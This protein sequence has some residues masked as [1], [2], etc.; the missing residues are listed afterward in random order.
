MFGSLVA[1]MSTQHSEAQ[2]S[3]AG[4]THTLYC[5]VKVPSWALRSP[6]T[7]PQLSTGA[8]QPCPSFFELSWECFFEGM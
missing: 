4:L 2:Q 6:S 1:A 7:Q 8:L 5:C 3:I